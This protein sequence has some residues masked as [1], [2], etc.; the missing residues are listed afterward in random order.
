[1]VWPQQSLEDLKFSTNNC[2][3]GLFHI[4]NPTFVED[5]RNQTFFWI[6]L[7]FWIST[8]AY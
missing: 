4:K 2:S 8:D 7:K 1:M 3:F 6:D 5:C